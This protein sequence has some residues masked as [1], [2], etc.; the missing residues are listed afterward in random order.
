MSSLPLSHRGEISLRCEISQRYHVRIMLRCVT[1]NYD[2]PCSPLLKSTPNDPVNILQLPLNQLY[3]P[4]SLLSV[5]PRGGHFEIRCRLQRVRYLPRRVR[6]SSNGLSTYNPSVYEFF[7]VETL[8][9]IQGTSLLRIHH[10]QTRHR[11]K[12]RSTNIHVRFAA[13]R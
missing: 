1:A 3:N 2:K 6:Y 7:I 11:V 4:E 10:F 12:L 5:G 13:S 9:L 8:K